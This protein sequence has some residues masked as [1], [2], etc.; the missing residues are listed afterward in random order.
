MT[1]IKKMPGGR[2]LKVSSVMIFTLLCLYNTGVSEVR[3]ANHDTTIR[4][5]VFDQR[6]RM[7]VASFGRGLWLID[8]SRITR[9]HDEKAQQ[10]YPMINN[11]LVADNHLWVATA[12]GGCVRI[13]TDSDQIEHVEQCD[14]FS[15][16]H[17]LV[18]TSSGTM[19]I[20]SVGSGSAFLSDNRWIP[21]SSSQPDNLAW[22]NAIVE[23]QNRLWL[24]TSTGL[25][26]TGLDISDWRPQY[27]QLNRG[28]NH[29]TRD[30][31]RLLIAAFT[32]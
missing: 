27:G 25:Y 6:D 26:S 21:V 8:G 32:K 13:N 24:G 20:G 14:G 19:L 17:A 16:L 31:D 12:G 7:W 15:K 28:V 4:S 5:I 10:P 22:V 2:M 23:W 18:R 30:N 9:F 3:F 1:D 29:L 11:L